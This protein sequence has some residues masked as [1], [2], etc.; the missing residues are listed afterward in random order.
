MPFAHMVAR[1]SAPEAFLSLAA[2]TDGEIKA[3]TASKQQAKSKDC[4]LVWHI[5]SM[6]KSY[7]LLLRRTRGIVRSRPIHAAELLLI[8]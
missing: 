5:P 7:H 8:H 2:C 6:S 1:W 3:P 4:N